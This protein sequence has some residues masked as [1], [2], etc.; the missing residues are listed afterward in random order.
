MTAKRKASE[1]LSEPNTSRAMVRAMA[2]LGRVQDDCGL[3]DEPDDLPEQRPTLKQPT[4]KVVQ[5]PLLFSDEA[6]PVSNAMARSALFAAIQGKNRQMFRDQH[7]ATVEGVEIIFTGQQLNQDDHDV[8]MQLV[9]MVQ[10]KPIGD[11][12]T[13]PANVIL[14]ALGRGTSGRE[15]EQLK[16]DMKRLLECLVTLR[17]TKSK[18]TY[19]GHLIDD[20]MQD[21]YLPQHKRHWCFRLNAKMLPFYARDSFSL[22]DWE[23]RKDLKRKDLARWLHGY[24]ATHAKPLPVKVETLRKLSGSKA[25]SLRHF[26][27]KLRAALD[28]LKAIG[29]IVSWQIDAAD[30]VTVDRGDA[31]TASQRHHLTRARP[32]RK[33]KD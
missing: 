2:K 17:N 29:A 12:V 19:Y 14:K 23:Q 4:G 24:Y 6:R 11:Y 22:I 27:E 20:A 32:R 25:K 5:F 33:R 18:V 16:A 28:N 3:L 15:H 1:L 9:H 7:L 13:L 30:L 21:E 10:H 31:I 8:L 26:R